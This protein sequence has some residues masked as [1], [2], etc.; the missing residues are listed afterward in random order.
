[1]ISG[2]TCVSFLALR[3]G[4]LAVGPMKMF[5]LGIKFPSHGL[6]R[7]CMI[8]VK[9]QFVISVLNVNIL[10]YGIVLSSTSVTGHVGCYLQNIP[11]GRVV[12]SGATCMKLNFM[13]CLHCSF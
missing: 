6:P 2:N 4:W 5:R 13:G 8:I 10:F 12:F 11:L 1:M 3:V 7:V 9:D